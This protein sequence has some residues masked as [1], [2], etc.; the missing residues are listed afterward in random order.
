[1]WFKNIQVF[2]CSSPLALNTEQLQEQL[3]EHRFQPCKSIETY[4]LGWVFP[5][6]TSDQL[7]HASNKKIL[8]CLRRQEKVIPAAVVNEILKERVEELELKDHRKVGR[9]EKLNIKEDILTEMTPK[10]FAKS[11]YTWGYVD[12]ANQWVIVD[13]ASSKKAEEFLDLLRQTIGSLPVIPLNT[14]VTPTT[15]MTHWLNDISSRPAGLALNGQCE[16]RSDLD[17]GSVIRC[18]QQELDA[19]DVLAHL[20]AGKQVTKLAIDWQE[21][22][23]CILNEDL[24]IKRLRFGDDLLEEAQDSYADEDPMTRLDADFTLMTLELQ[25]FLHELIEWLGGEHQSH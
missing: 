4:R 6:A 2:K 14:E 22:V 13:A 1:M 3:N 7:L 25:R 11:S 5:A 24:S 15:L 18:K 20:Q 21:R 16:L 23:Q 9:K 8:L 10:A 19:E 17:E 12:L